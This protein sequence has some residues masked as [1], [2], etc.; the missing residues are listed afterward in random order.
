MMGH[1]RREAGDF[2]KSDE[3]PDFLPA[4]ASSPDGSATLLRIHVSPGVRGESRLTG[5][6]TWRKA[7]TAA[8]AAPAREGQ[9]NAE[10]CRLLAEALDV[11]VRAVEVVEGQ[12]ARLKRVRVEG[13]TVEATLTRIMEVE[14]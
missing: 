13:L 10:L 8:I 14:Y 11:P 12:K 9:A 7:L 5:Y 6:D 4:L 2:P 3:V 1:T